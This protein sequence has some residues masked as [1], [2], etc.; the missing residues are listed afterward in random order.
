[1]TGIALPMLGVFADPNPMLLVADCPD[2]LAGL[3]RYG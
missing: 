2:G 1:M 3:Q